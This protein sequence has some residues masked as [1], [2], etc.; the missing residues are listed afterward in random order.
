MLWS[1]SAISFH[2]QTITGRGL[3]FSPTP[4]A[5]FSINY[6]LTL[7]TVTDFMFCSSFFRTENKNKFTG[8]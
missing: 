1:K 4:L 2:V 3:F 8:Q 6:E 5:I 7:D